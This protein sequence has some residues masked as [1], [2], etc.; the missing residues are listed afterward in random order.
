MER[1]GALIN[2]LQQQYNQQ[3]QESALLNT[4]LL[5]VTELQTNTTT[6]TTVGKV[7]VIMPYK[8]FDSVTGVSVE[9]STD[10]TLSEVIESNILPEAIKEPEPAAQ[11]A[12]PEIT[13]EPV[14]IEPGPLQT[15]A[16]TT[17]AEE[18]YNEVMEDVPTLV[19]Q[20]PKVVYELNDTVQTDEPSINDK[21]KQQVP[22]TGNKLQ[23][24]PIRDLRRAIG[25]NDKYLFIKELFRNDEVAYERSIKTI[26]AFHILPEA[27]YWMQREM[28]YKLGWDESSPTVQM[29]YQLVRRRFS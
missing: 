17:L 21:L 8:P 27:E 3:V 15:Y 23:S 10:E 18:K 1:V 24:E 26:N 25:I 9:N 19:Q 12:M 2:R 7:S 28:K 22:E 29:F 11:P 20:Q 4:A 16:V 14:I 5:L 13:E 6:E